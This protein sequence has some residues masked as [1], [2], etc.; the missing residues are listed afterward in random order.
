MPENTQTLTHYPPPAH[1]HVGNGTIM[2][3]YSQP[4]SLR[5]QANQAQAQTGWQGAGQYPPGVDAG[6]PGQRYPNNVWG[7]RYHIP[8]ELPAHRTFTQYIDEQIARENPASRLSD[9]A[10]QSSY[11]SVCVPASDRS[12]R[13]PYPTVTQHY[14]G[15]HQVAAPMHGM[16]VHGQASQNY[17]PFFHHQGSQHQGSGLTHSQNSA[18]VS[19]PLLS[20]TICHDS[21]PRF[22]EDPFVFRHKIE[23]KD[24]FLP[25]F[26]DLSPRSSVSSV[27]SVDGRTRDHH[28]ISHNPGRVST[29]MGADVVASP[30]I[31][32]LP[33]SASQNSKPQNK[34]YSDLP[35]G[36]RKK[37]LMEQKSM[38]L[39]EQERL[40]K[41]L[42]EQETLL[43][44]K[45]EQ[46]R[47]QQA[48]QQK[49]LQV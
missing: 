21:T 23:T 49:R 32:A 7:Q 48:R 44:S 38:L 17:P 11:N 27:M 2:T 39:A 4:S 25:L 13:V 43:H 26:H 19:E 35:S 40:K 5:Y 33:A 6:N 37:Q 12:H 46:L 41:I 42:T 16:S 45:Q 47:E 9:Y 10:H 22:S 24:D 20:S 29:T 28:F 8:S 34:R 14:D 36:E 18:A 1:Y 30:I 31:H 3:S 15:S